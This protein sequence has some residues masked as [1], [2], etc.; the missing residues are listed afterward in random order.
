MGKETHIEYDY[1][2]QFEGQP[3]LAK[4]TTDPDGTLTLT[5]EDGEGRLLRLQRPGQTIDCFY[6]L[7]GRLIRQT[8]NEE[9]TLRQ[10]SPEGWVTSVTQEGATTR[11]LYNCDGQITQI[12]KP[13]GVVIHQEYDALGRRTGLTAGDLSYTY[14]PEPDYDHFE[15]GLSIERTLDSRGRLTQL[16]LPDGSSI[17]FEWGASHLLRISRN[18]YTHDY[19]DHNLWGLPTRESLAF[20]HGEL[21]RRY[22]NSGRILEIAHPSFRERVEER[23]CHGRVLS[24]S[25]NPYSYDER[26]HLVDSTSDALTFDADRRLIQ[27]DSTHFTYDDLNR[28]VR[29]EE[30]DFAREYTY[31]RFDRRMTCTY[32]TSSLWGWTATHT[33]RFIHYDTH[34]I[35][36]LDESGA[37]LSLRVLPPHSSESVMVELS[38]ELY[39]P[40]HDHRSCVRALLSQSG[41]A[42]TYSY[43]PHGLTTSSDL[44]NPYCFSGQ[45]TDLSS[46]LVS[47]GTRLYDP[48]SHRWLA[49]TLL[50][51]AN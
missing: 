4:R 36:E 27:R 33:T 10:Y 24:A 3:V 49:P 13:S 43:T 2:A 30:S 48:H 47:Y 1:T 34:E 14:S 50:N 44:S 32:Y 29:I 28:L 26:G 15:N 6:D 42:A 41:L 37:F 8:D 18:G 11:Y 17:S 7:C 25:G 9:E 45:P 46:G 39:V 35:G 40:I 51:P 23:D 31:D 5:Y 38:G 19:L 16:L 22:D 20:D 12:I 21:I